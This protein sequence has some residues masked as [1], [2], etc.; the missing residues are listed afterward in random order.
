MTKERLAQ[1]IIEVIDNFRF[2]GDTEAEIHTAVVALLESLEPKDPVR[3]ESWGFPED[4]AVV[5]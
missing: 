1:R 5:A 4:R 3:F 2:V